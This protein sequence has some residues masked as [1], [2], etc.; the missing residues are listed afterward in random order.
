MWWPPERTRLRG[1]NVAGS[2]LLAVALAVLAATVVVPGVAVASTDPPHT[3][4]S[5]ARI[6][7]SAPPDS[8]SP[9]ST[10]RGYSAG[11]I[12]D[13]GSGAK[14]GVPTAERGATSG[15]D[16]TPMGGAPEVDT[17]TNDSS[18][19]ETR[20]HDSSTGQT[21]TFA[22]TFERLP[23]RRGEV[24]VRVETTVPDAVTGVTVEPPS[25]ATVVETTGF[26]ATGD[27][28]S[29]WHWERSASAA[30]RPAI[31]YVADVERTDDGALV[32][33][34]VGDWALFDWRRVDLVW[35]F[36]HAGGGPTPTVRERAV[37]VVGEGV[38]G[39]AYAYLGP[40]ET[41]ERTVGG[42]TIRL[43]VPD[44]AEP[45]E[46]PATLIDAL[47]G[48]S[49]DLRIGGRAERLTVFVAPAPIAV[50]GRLSRTT[51]DG[52]Q[53]AVV[54]ADRP[55]ATPDNTWFHEYVHSRQ[56]Y[57]TAEGLEW[58]DDASAE[59]YAALLTYRQGRISR[60]AF[61]DYVRTDRYGDA[62]LAESA[63]V[64]DPASYFKGM[65]VLAA[66]DAEVRAASGGDR[67]LDDVLAG[68]NAHDGPV[69]RPVFAR[70]ARR[71][72]GEPLDDW[73]ETYVGTAASPP[74]PDYLDDRPSTTT[75]DDRRFGD[76]IAGLDDA[77]W[78]GRLCFAAATLVG[79]GTLLRRRRSR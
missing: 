79:V 40:A 10:S 33:T 72:A 29:A 43:V 19:V 57:G 25:G 52:R 32:T 42:E 56:A 38:V 20:T 3:S 24:L 16:R 6:P 49:R 58:L 64:T 76:A 15:P 4:G 30:Q 53:D 59:Y 7:E 75:A 36:A 21:L 9:D 11:A 67:S 74:V 34:S 47:A 44:A 50:A 41:Y 60:E 65:R 18:A 77:S 48:A 35:R 27:E 61:Y 66:L 17:G 8:S 31:T 69:T 78:L 39:P 23:G 46:S 37:G 55:I 1:R 54:G 26:E 12:D 28:V 14:P 2:R 70:Q 62:V 13:P 45:A 22:Y 71:A 73:L 5:P 68:V 63:S 51:A